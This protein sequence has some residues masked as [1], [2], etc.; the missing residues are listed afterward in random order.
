MI[1]YGDGSTAS[2]TVGF[3]QVSI[4]GAVVQKQCVELAHQVSPTFAQEPA[5]DGLLGLAF[6]AINTVQPQRQK[7]FFENIMNNL[8]QPLFTANLEEDNSGT[9]EFGK[10]DTTKFT[11]PLQYAPVDNSA[12]FWQIDSKSF[13]VGGTQ[14]S[15]PS[16]N[17][18]ILDTGTTLLI[19]DDAIVKAYYS[20]V[21]GA[22]LDANAGGYVYPCSTTPPDFGV[23]I[24]NGMVT[25][26]VLFPSVGLTETCANYVDRVRI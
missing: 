2:G 25:I 21:N 19:M 18:F 4:G 14:Q 9:Y 6:S 26:K 3:D 5:T 10:I 11:G 24:G 8:D 7:T 17:P 1:R 22:K 15:C 12:G 13:A 16:C 23:A 20:Q